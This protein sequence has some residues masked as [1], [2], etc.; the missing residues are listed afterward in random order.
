MADV[1]HQYDYQPKWWVILLIA[2]HSIL[3]ASVGAYKIAHPWPE[4]LPALYWALL[5]FSLLGLARIGVV[6]V[7]R[8]SLRRRVAFTPTSLLLP[9]SG[10]SSGEEVIDYQTITGLKL[11]GSRGGEPRYLYV[12]HRDGRR[13]IAE[14]FLPSRA[15]FEDVC[16]LLTDRVGAFEWVGQGEPD[17]V[18]PRRGVACRNRAATCQAEVIQHEQDAAADVGG[19]DA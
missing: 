2:G 3:G 6:A 15:A 12:T 1:G 10:W 14:A 4:N 5:V 11:S 19:P 8:V 17:A 7:E 18:C 9:K 13:R 16:R